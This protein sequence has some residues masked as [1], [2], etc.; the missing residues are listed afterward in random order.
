MTDRV[1]LADARKPKLT[2]SERSAIEAATFY[3]PKRT[4]STYASDAEF[5]RAQVDW[6]NQAF[7]IKIIRRLTGEDI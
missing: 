2:K 6:E 3:G 7:L 5:R 4:R 1:S